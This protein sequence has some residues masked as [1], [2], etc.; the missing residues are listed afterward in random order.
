MEVMP[1]IADKPSVARESGVS[2]RTIY[3]IVSGKRR[4]VEYNTADK[5]SLALGFELPDPTHLFFPNQGIIKIEDSVC[6]GCGVHRDQKTPG[7]KTCY[8][9]HYKRRVS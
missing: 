5:L 9:R 3:A 4:Y 1:Q 2:V 6:Y 7:C 8:S